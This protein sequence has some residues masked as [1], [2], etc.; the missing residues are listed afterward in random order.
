MK[1][2]QWAV[3]AVA[4][5]VVSAASAAVWVNYRMTHTEQG[6]A[7]V[8]GRLEVE[9]LEIATKF[10][11]QIVDVA[12]Q[13]GDSV[14]AGDVIARMDPR[15]Y[16]AQLQG[17]QAMQ[18]RADRAYQRASGENRVRNQYLR[19]AQLDLKNT[20]ALHQQDLVSDAELEKRQAQRDGE[21]AGVSVASAAMGEAQ[22]AHQEAEAGMKR[23]RQAIDDHTMRAPVN[24]RIEYRIVEPG[25]VIPAGGRVATLLNTDNVYMTVFLPTSQAGRVRVGDEARLVL[26]AA[27]DCVL[28]AKVIFVADEAQFT[29]KYVETANE[30][31]KMMYRVKLKVPPELTRRYYGLIKSGMTGNGYVRVAANEPWPD[32]LAVRL[33]QE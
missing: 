10:A 19:V 8:N 3:A 1:K 13:E 11:G 22:A 2:A 29:P 28:P 27:P 12:V 25:A 7:Q 32:K 23:L 20:E 24:G 18:L 30:R 9:R 5:A 15:D 4:M 17:V 6:I 26:D 33:P 21:V 31:E 16:V 14:K